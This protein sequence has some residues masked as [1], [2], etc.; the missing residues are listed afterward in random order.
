MIEKRF[1]AVPPQL[2]TANGTQSGV[3]TIASEACKLFKVKQK[4]ILTANTL[5][6]LEVEIKEIDAND[7]IQVGPVPGSVP[8]QRTGIDTRIDVS[9]YTVALGATIS[10]NEQ[11]RP[12]IDNAE[13][14][15]A[16]YQEEPA[17]AVRSI[18]V[19][20]CGDTY[21]EDNPLPI[22]FDGTISIGSVEIKD[23]DGDILEVNTD[24]SINVNIINS[25]PTSTPGLDIRYNEVSAVVAGVETTVISLVA[26]GAGFR[27][28]KIY[29]AGENIALFKIKVNSN[30]IIA[31]RTFWGNL[32]EEFSFESFNNG[33]KL[34]T[35]DTLL[36]TVLHYKP[37]TAN[38]EASIMGLDL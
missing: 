29:V 22:A 37:A 18:L 20:D 24:G 32:N 17:V 8:G 35:G 1:A 34:N 10:A 28:N 3:I 19:D 31:K 4:V 12:A 25:V 15:R 36:V 14:V 26:G 21:N 13:I 6:N 23:P 2:F 11:K 33:L 27:V 7:N 30:P 38:F 5:P 16:T 9:A